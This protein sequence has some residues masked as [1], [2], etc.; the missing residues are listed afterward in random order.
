MMGAAT[1][2]SMETTGNQF[3]NLSKRMLQIAIPIAISGIVTQVQ[4]LIDTAFLAR[5]S[6]TT[7]TGIVMSGSD[8]LSAVGNVFFPY[9][10]GLSF[11]WSI[12]TGVVILVS[13]RLGAKEPD[14]AKQYAMTAFKYNTML[15]WLV[16]LF[17]L[18]FA[19]NIF[20]AMGV[21]QPILSLSLEYLRFI[22]LELIF[23]GTSSTMGA[24]L[25]G[26]GITR[27]EMFTGVIR[28]VLHV[29][30]DF[31]FIFGNLGFPQW[32]IAG[33]GIASSL[34]GLIATIL[35]GVIFFRAK[36]LSF[37]PD[38]KSILKAPFQDYK[39][40]LRVGLPVGVEDM[41]WNFG[42]L[43]LAYFLNLLSAD[44][45]GIYR[46][47][48]QIEI[49]P[50]FFYTGLA[51]AVITLVGNKSG[52]RDTAG[53]KKVTLLGTA[54]TAAFCSIFTASFLLFPGVILSIF[55]PDAGLIQRAA[56]LLVIT[57]FTMI[58]RAINIISGYGIRGYGDTMWMLATQIFGICFIVSLSY[59]LMFTLGFGMYGMFMAMFADETLRG[60]INTIRF[61]R[62]ERSIFYKGLPPAPAVSGTSMM[63]EEAA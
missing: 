39:T 24:A 58:P 23:L 47:V 22:S 15:S 37:R 54:Y 36:N 12:S 14:K 18:L 34:S 16:Y 40:V 28:S 10:V 8:I 2:T 7:V 32:G 11:L 29:I 50:I 52:E 13:Q 43:I 21:H 27:P 41:L 49:T 3:K 55:T 46:L 26:M 33:A 35:L 45:V 56:P 60:L 5:Y 53:A 42:N 59:A 51:R 25:Q 20:S 9:L 62:G 31:L 38:A 17:W 57:A 44:A 48:F 63:T 30:F 61:Y 19:G 6:F 4:M 1:E